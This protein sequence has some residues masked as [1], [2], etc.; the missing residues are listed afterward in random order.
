M[1]AEQ[2]GVQRDLDIFWIVF[3]YISITVPIFITA[4]YV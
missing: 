2:K 3:M 1:S 4:G